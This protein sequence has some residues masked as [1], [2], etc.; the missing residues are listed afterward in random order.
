MKILYQKPQLIKP[1]TVTTIK[2]EPMTLLNV[3]N[4][5]PKDNHQKTPRPKMMPIIN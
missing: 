3:E 2:A 5:L 4:C 1:L